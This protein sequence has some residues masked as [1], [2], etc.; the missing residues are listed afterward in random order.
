MDNNKRL[1]DE[2]KEV[3]KLIRY[4]KREIEEDANFQPR[5]EFLLERIPVLE[6][7]LDELMKQYK[8]VTDWLI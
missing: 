1:K 6:K 7:Q 5:L 8:K 2:I 4:Y 3:K